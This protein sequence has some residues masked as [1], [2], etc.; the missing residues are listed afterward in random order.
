MQYLNWDFWQKTFYL[1][2]T[3]SGL[4]E[5]YV[6]DGERRRNALDKNKR[7]LRSGFHTTDVDAVWANFSRWQNTRI[8]VGPI[9]DILAEVQTDRVAY[10]HLDMNCGP[11]ETAAF[12]YFWDRLVSGA[13]VL[14]DDYGYAGSEPQKA[15]MDELAAAR[16]VKI[17][18]LPTG[19]GLLIKPT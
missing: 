12:T 17:L 19:Q 11:P 8:V 5:C 9:P 6:S 10:L 7:L 15:A 18:S 16:N 2:D 3:F 13:F 14:L 4:D 1:L